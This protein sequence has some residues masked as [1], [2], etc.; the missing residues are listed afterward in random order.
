MGL[1]QVGYGR[2]VADDIRDALDTRGAD[3]TIAVRVTVRAPRTRVTGRWGD[4]VKIA[5]AAPPVEGAANDELR[6]FVADLLDVRAADVRLV[7]GE[8]SRN[9]VVAVTGVTIDTVA[10]RLAG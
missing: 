4:A 9:K 10:A 3:V 7:A 5:L 8:R 2:R 1:I 6:R